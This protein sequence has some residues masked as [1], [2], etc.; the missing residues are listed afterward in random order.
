MYIHVDMQGTSV[1]NS[2]ACGGN[3]QVREPILGLSSFRVREIVARCKLS[4]LVQARFNFQGLFCRSL[5]QVSFVGL[6]RPSK[7]TN[8]KI[9]K[10]TIFQMCINLKNIIFEMCMDLFCG[11]LLCIDLFCGSLLC[12][13]LFCGSLLNRALGH[14]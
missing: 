5:L 14:S 10:N 8:E 3:S 6:W 1:I 7:E 9:F 2:H 11:S 13:D 12:I 4:H